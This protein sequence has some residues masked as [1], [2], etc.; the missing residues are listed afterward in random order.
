M[1]DIIMPGHPFNAATAATA[2]KPPRAKETIALLQTISSQSP[3]PSS[4]STH[5]TLSLAD[6]SSAGGAQA[7]TAPQV[8]TAL[9]LFTLLSNPPTYAMPLAKAK[10]ALAARGL[11][12]A[13]AAGPLGV[14]SVGGQAL[15]TRALYGCIAKRLLKIDRGGKEQILKFDV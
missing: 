9:L 5:S 8:L 14:L 12:A 4:P 13:A 10:E 7:A 2:N 15:E 11:G 6:T 1:G 3:S